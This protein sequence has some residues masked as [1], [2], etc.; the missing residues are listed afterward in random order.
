MEKDA[1]MELGAHT[2]ALISRSLRGTPEA[3]TRTPDQTAI[4]RLRGYV[5]ATDHTEIDD[6]EVTALFQNIRR[7]YETIPAH[8]VFEICEDM[9]V[10]YKNIYAKSEEMMKATNASLSVI[11]Y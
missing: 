8:A 6:D 4:G 5:S 1:L 3:E 10:I 11:K 2:A 7:K 9:E